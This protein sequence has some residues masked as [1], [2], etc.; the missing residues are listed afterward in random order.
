[1]S[2]S[3]GSVYSDDESGGPASGA[4]SGAESEVCI[5]IVSCKRCHRE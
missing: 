4:A 2:D 3:E 1:M 5:L